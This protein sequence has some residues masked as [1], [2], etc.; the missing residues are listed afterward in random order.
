MRKN[1]LVMV[2]TLLTA[3]LII[4]SPAIDVSKLFAGRQTWMLEGFTGAPDVPAITPIHEFTAVPAEGDY[5]ICKE[6][7]GE[8][9]LVIFYLSDDGND[10]LSGSADRE[11]MIKTIIRLVSP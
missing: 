5:Y 1:A 7:P 10:P 4:D 3:V 2:L 8:N 6:S 9:G 11:G